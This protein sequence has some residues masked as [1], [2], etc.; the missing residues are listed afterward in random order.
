MLAETL[1]LVLLDL[2]PPLPD[3]HCPDGRQSYQSHGGKLCLMRE[4]VWLYRLH[5]RSFWFGHA[6]IFASSGFWGTVVG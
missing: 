1:F 6:H 5:Y 2:V 4:T 3:Q